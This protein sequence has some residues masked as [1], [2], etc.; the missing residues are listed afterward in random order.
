MRLRSA[1]LLVGLMV[2]G[3][4][5]SAG[6]ANVGAQESSLVRSIEVEGNTF[7]DT[8]TI[9]ASILKTKINQ[10]AVEQQI[11]DDLR[12][13]YDLGYFQDATASFEP[14][15]AGVKVIFHVVENPVVREINFSGLASVPFAEYEKQMKTQPGY[16]LNVHDLWEDL[17][18]LREWIATEYGYLARI[19]DLSAD[20]DGR[21]DV[22]LVPTTLKD[23]VIEGNA[24]TK[25]FVIERELSFKVGEPVNLQ[26]VDQSLRKVLMLGFFDEI[27]RDFSEEDDPDETVLTIDLTE[28]KT[29]SAT[30]GV[31]YSTQDRLVGFIEAADENFLGRGQRVN[32][33]V[34]FGKKLQEYELGFYEPYIDKS[35]T[36]L[37]I[38]LYRKTK[39]V[40]A[41]HRDTDEMLQIQGTTNGGDLTLGRPF[42]EFTRG[43]LT[44]KIENNAYDL[45]EEPIKEPEKF[46]DYKNRTIGFGV[47]TNTSDHPF[48]P[49]EGYKNDAYLELGTRLLG[50]EMQYAKL[51][52]E[53]SR[54]FEI[55]DGGYV[56]AVRGLGGRLLGGDLGREKFKIGGADTL[57]GYTYGGYPTSSGRPSLEGDHMLVMNAEFRFPILE[58]VTGVVFTDW[59]TTWDKG[60]SMSLNDLAN[61]FGLGVRL[62]TPLGL[63]RLDYGWGK[64]AEDERKGQFYFGIGQMF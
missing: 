17:Y 27:S 15:T 55:I 49:T 13:I 12:S 39:P 43:R 26:K 44:F 37:G 23:I 60:E 38:N 50:G 29:G 58:K 47:N 3:V 20:T 16:I 40:N 32:A 62:D 19:A 6:V 64:N 8:E 52:L 18:G 7:I 14:A 48:N 53:H 2:I 21:I 33:T 31:S 25:D 42:G 56:L 54:Y 9:K 51:R 35:G 10:P 11:L 63:L 36:S 46:N 5:L 34:R 28:R 4:L 45:P 57:R 61:S 41:I 24:K 30:F 22:E 1:K 59:G